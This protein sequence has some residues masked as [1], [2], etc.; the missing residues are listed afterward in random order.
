MP[1]NAHLI[2][3]SHGSGG[4]PWV[5]ADLARELVRRGFTVALPQHHADNCRYRSD[6]GP[7]SWRLRPG[8]VSAAI[9]LVAGHPPLAAHLQFVSVGWR[10]RWSRLSTV[11]ARTG[12]LA[13]RV[14]MA[15]SAPPSCRA[16]SWPSGVF[17]TSVAVW[18]F[19]A[20]S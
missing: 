15:T 9:D 17:M 8:E 10:D 12:V 1:G 16:T 18:L 7:A 6:P 14:L 3:I 2:V 19:T 4:W 11:P 20:R 13:G 5:H